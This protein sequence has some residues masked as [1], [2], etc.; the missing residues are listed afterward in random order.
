MKEYKISYTD[1]SKLV[2]I[3]KHIINIHKKY[4][5]DLDV[6]TVYN[7]IFEVINGIFE[8]THKK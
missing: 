6:H 2:D 3:E 1:L 4:G 5:A 8:Y 7:D